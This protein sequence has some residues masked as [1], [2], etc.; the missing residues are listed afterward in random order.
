MTGLQKSDGGNIS[1]LSAS[2]KDTTMI[3][4]PAEKRVFPKLHNIEICVLDQLFIVKE[5]ISY[6]E[7]ILL[8]P[9]GSR[10]NI[11]WKAWWWLKTKSQI[12]T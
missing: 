9:M 5:G 6:N 12:K 7:W 1:A 11:K 3:W 2:Y 8:C 10:A 4:A